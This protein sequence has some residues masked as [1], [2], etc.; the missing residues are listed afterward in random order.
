MLSVIVP[1]YNSEQY[2]ERCV[3]SLMEQTLDD[4]EYVFINDCSTDR[5]IDLLHCTI[6]DYPKRLSNI[7]IISN[8]HNFGAAKSRAIGLKNTT[9]D[10]IIN[11][12]SDDWMESEMLRLLY[13]AAISKQVDMVFCDFF[14]ESKGSTTTRRQFCALNRTSILQALLSGKQQGSLW[15]H[16]IRAELYKTDNLAWPSENMAEDLTLIL[17]FALKSQKFAYIDKALYHY[18]SVENSLSKSHSKTALIRQALEMEQ[19]FKLIEMKLI[20][21]D[22]NDYIIYRKFFTKRWLLPAITSTQECSIWHNIHHEVNLKIFLC[23]LISIRDKVI[24]LLVL[25]RLYPLVKRI[26]KRNT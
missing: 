10:Y 2:I 7:K 19:N 3:R 13:N 21:P 15:N 17:Q 24:A 4:I 6:K 26:F 8:S 22:L 25:T 1:I 11:C 23:P 20:S 9:G 5:S 16:L 14:V 12:D 18:R